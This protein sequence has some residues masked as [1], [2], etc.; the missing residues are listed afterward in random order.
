MLAEARTAVTDTRV[1]WHRL[2]A[3]RLDTG[4]SGAMDA[5][6]CNSA[7]WQTDVRATIR[8][9]SRVLRPGG[10]LVF[11]VGADKLADHAD[12]GSPDPL[13][14]LMEDFAAREY[15]WTAPAARGTGPA[16]QELTESWLRHELGDTGF[17]VE[18]V[19]ALTCQCDLDEYRAWLSI[20][21]FT[22]RRYGTLSHEQRMAALDHAYHQLKDSPEGREPVISA[23]VAFA[24]RRD[25]P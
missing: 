17:S 1:R 18:Q 22:R 5:V 6:A 16:G 7:I 21:V 20:P 10:R 11:N 24:A 25:H 2:T 8:A 13:T 23:W 19:R 14:E 15:G 12:P 9:V 4:I 3:E